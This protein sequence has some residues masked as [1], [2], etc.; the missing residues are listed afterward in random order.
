M[1]EYRAAVP[2]VD[3]LAQAAD[4]TDPHHTRKLRTLVREN[5]WVISTSP[6]SVAEKC[7]PSIRLTVRSLIFNGKLVLPLY[8]FNGFHCRTVNTAVDDSDIDRASLAEEARVQLGSKKDGTLVTKKNVISILQKP[9]Q[10]SNYKKLI[11]FFECSMTAIICCRLFDKSR[12][13]QHMGDNVVTKLI[14]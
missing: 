8:L 6:S 7:P 11:F 13:L 4:F 3:R 14:M 10:A 9:S 12:A 5:S 2:D 1:I